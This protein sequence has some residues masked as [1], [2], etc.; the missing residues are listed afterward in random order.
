MRA[1]GIRL[2]AVVFL[3]LIGQAEWVVGYEPPIRTIVIR[4]SDASP[5]DLTDGAALYWMDIVVEDFWAGQTWRG[6][7][8]GFRPIIGGDYH[9]RPGYLAAYG[10]EYMDLIWDFY[11][12]FY[13]GPDPSRIDQVIVELFVADDYPIEVMA[14]TQSEW[15]A[16]F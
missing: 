16:D 11:G 14:D 4:L 9:Q 1:T 2:F 13:N 7:E 8:Y 3:F 10:E 5:E 12:P 6:S 15:M